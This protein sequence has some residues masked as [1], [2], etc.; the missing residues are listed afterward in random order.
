MVLSNRTKVGI[1]IGVSVI[2]GLAFHLI[3]VLLLVFAVFLIVWGQEPQ[4]TEEFI[5]GL[6]GGNHL[7]KALAQ[8]E[9]GPLIAGRSRQR[10]VVGPPLPILGHARQ[11]SDAAQI[12]Y[13]AA[14]AAAAGGNRKCGGSELAPF[15][16]PI[17]QRAHRRAAPASCPPASSQSVANKSRPTTRSSRPCFAPVYSIQPTH[18]GSQGHRSGELNRNDG[19]S[20]REEV[21]SMKSLVS[22]HPLRKTFVLAIVLTAALP[23]FGCYTPGERAAGG[24]IIGGLGGAAIGAAVSG[25]LAGP[26]IAGAAIGAASG[27]VIGAATAPRRYYY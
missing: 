12:R 26:A 13:P 5:A 22:E 24:G 25:G 11:Q 7:L 27:A 21:S 1:A 6:P 16:R 19:I 8:L 14:A 2:A 3:A 15:P 4:R 17:C 20:I 10:R 23:L 18:F 9:L